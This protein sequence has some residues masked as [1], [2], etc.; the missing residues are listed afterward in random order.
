ME[1]EGRVKGREGGR[2]RK[3]RERVKMKG[4]KSV[5]ADQLVNHF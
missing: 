3:E 5:I 4:F 2:R 1:R